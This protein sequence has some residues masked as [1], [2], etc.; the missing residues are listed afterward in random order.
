MAQYTTRV[1]DQTWTTTNTWTPTAP[2]GGPNLA[3]GD[4]VVINHTVLV[5]VNLTNISGKISG[6][7]SLKLQAGYTLDAIP[8]G[9]T[10]FSNAGG[11]ITDNYGTLTY[12]VSGGVLTTNRST[13]IVSNNNA[14]CTIG[15]NSGSVT[16]N[17]GTVTNNA[18]SVVNNYGVITSNTGTVEANGNEGA[19]YGSILYSIGIITTNGVG[20]TVVAQSG[21]VLTN[22]GTVFLASSTAS[23]VVRGSQNGT[24][25][26][27]TGVVPAA[28]DVRKDTAVNGTVGLLAVPNRINVL[29][30]EPTDNTTGT[31]VSP[32]PG[33]VREF[34]HYGPGN[35][36]HGTL[37][38]PMPNDVRNDISYDGTS[39]TGTIVVPSVS[40][41]RQDTPVDSSLAGTC[42]VPAASDVR[43]GVEVDA[44]TGT[45]AAS[46]PLR[47]HFLSGAKA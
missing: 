38:L 30:G 47:C 35:A 17:R 34:T 9:F 13:G 46:H 18:Q 43:K 11:V 44:T 45:R 10:W 7:G 3:T 12:Q 25:Q 37:D 6:S 14:G 29:A 36:T 28:A 27:K 32:A 5:N 4:T 21:S 42:R 41:V 20:A 40:D 23:I 2:T 26:I 8:A 19:A 33:D 39:Q 16:Y 22:Y 31:L 1:S 24:V 15:T